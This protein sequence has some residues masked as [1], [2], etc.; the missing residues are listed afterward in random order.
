MGL[1]RIVKICLLGVSLAIAQAPLH[2]SRAE[3]DLGVWSS[4]ATM[5]EQ[6]AV[7]GAFA[8]IMA[9]QSLVDEKLG[10]LWAERRNYSGSIIRRAA[11]LEG[12]ADINDDDIDILLNRYSMWLLNNLASPA[13]AEILSPDARDAAREMV[14]DVC[15][16]LYT[17]AD[18]AIVQKHPAL[19]S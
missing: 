5:A 9:M 7:C 1:S 16:T 18:K 17:Q 6:G 19:A 3:I 13:N 12:L 11:S 4:Y 15:D 8:D 2:A 10:R 14:A